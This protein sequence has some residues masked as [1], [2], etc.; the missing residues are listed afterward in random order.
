MIELLKE[1]IMIAIVLSV[2][3]KIYPKIAIWEL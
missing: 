2:S 3:R 1:F